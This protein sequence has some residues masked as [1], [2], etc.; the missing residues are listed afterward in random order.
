MEM[1]I[2]EFRKEYR[3]LSNFWPC[4]VTYDGITF[5]SSE[6]A[7]QA[8]KTE[9]YELRKEFEHL[10]AKEAKLKGQALTAIRSDWDEIKPT[11]MYEVCKS[12][13]DQNPELKEKL[14]ETGEV[15][16]VEGNDWGD[17]YWGVCNGKGINML[18]K[19][20]MRLRSEYQATK[21]M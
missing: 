9:S 10:S 11:V 5:N 2:L 12:K 21:N 18:G 14:I 13:F 15:K 4:S 17:T 20:L 6:A 1:G 3:W 7:Y 16:L 8:S 19:V